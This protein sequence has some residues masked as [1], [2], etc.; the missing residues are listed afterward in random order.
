MRR[1]FGDAAI[2]GA[3]RFAA[4]RD[5]PDRLLTVERQRAGDP[6]AQ[7]GA[8]LRFT[9]SSLLGRGSLGCVYRA[10]DRETGEEVAVKTLEGAGPEALYR[11]KQ[12]VRAV[13]SVRHPNLVRLHEL[14]V[15]EA[16]CF[17]TMELVEGDDFL[18][19]LRGT[20][21]GPA[22]GG[23]DLD[24]LRSATAQLIAGLSA[25]H[26]SGRLHRDVKPANVRVRPDG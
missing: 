22:A 4:P 18:A 19:W 6:A 12:E 1:G 25:L 5:Y 11:L 3:W 17:F 10:R 21:A 20:E 23:I 2:G 16:D 15:G 9:R 14:F 8:S 13:A 26:E 7:T 24:R